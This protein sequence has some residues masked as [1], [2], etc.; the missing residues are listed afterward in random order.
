[1]ILEVGLGMPEIALWQRD[2]PKTQQLQ[3]GEICKR[4]TC[5]NTWLRQ[6]ARV[7]KMG[8]GQRMNLEEINPS[9]KKSTGGGGD[10]LIE[11]DLLFAN[12]RLFS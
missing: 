9:K 1:M 8:A 6:G 11:F 12:S 2:E 7:M 10:G 4:V 3:S 5:Y